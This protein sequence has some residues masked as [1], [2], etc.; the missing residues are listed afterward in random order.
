M[1]RNKCFQLWVELFADGNFAEHYTQVIMNT[2]P[3]MSF[4]GKKKL[5][6]LRKTK[7]GRRRRN[8]IFTDDESSDE[9]IGDDW[10]R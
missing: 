2:L 7:R 8:E 1:W 3:I 4:F 6:V 9:D 5:V 10:R